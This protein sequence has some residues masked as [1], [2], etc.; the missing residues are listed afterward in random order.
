MSFSELTWHLGWQEGA[1]GGDNAGP[2]APGGPIQLKTTWATWPS[3]GVC[4]RALADPQ[5]A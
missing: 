5:K 2:I 4:R 1:E 3:T